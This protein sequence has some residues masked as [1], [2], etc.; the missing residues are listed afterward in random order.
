MPLRGLDALAAGTSSRTPPPHPCSRLA[1][2][3]HRATPAH[4]RRFAGHAPASALSLSLLHHDSHCRSALVPHASARAQALAMARKRAT[5]P[6]M[7]TPTRRVAESKTRV[8]NPLREGDGGIALG[9]LEEP[10]V[11]P[12]TLDLSAPAWR[13]LTTF[14]LGWLAC[15]AASSPDHRS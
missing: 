3:G 8:R 14:L 9:G 13:S 7:G 11:P 6:G 2:A 10:P 12:A 5:R 1:L 4:P 15:P